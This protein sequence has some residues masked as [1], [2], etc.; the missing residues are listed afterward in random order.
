MVIARVR[1]ATGRTAAWV[2]E[3]VVVKADV[4]LVAREAAAREASAREVVARVVAAREVA[5]R[6]VAVREVAAREV[7]VMGVAVMGVA[8][9]EAVAREAVLAH[10]GTAPNCRNCSCW[11]CLHRVV[12]CRSSDRLCSMRCSRIDSLATRNTKG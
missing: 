4:A 1:K 5:A 10:T 9:M 6:E 3:R 11:G 8:A 2:V 12:W 7:A